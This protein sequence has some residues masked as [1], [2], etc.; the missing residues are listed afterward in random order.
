MV[1]HHAFLSSPSPQS[2][3]IA[4]RSHSQQWEARHPEAHLFQHQR[5]LRLPDN[6][7]IL[8]GPQDEEDEEDEHVG[9]G[10]RAGAG[11]QRKRKAP[12]NGEEKDQYQQGRVVTDAGPTGQSDAAA[13]AAAVGAASSSSAA[14]SES[15]QQ[16]QQQEQEQ[17][18]QEP[19]EQEPEDPAT[20]IRGLEGG[21]VGGFPG[22][23]PPPPRRGAAPWEQALL[24][25]EVRGAAAGAAGAAASLLCEGLGRRPSNGAAWE[26][27]KT[28]P[29]GQDVGEEHRSHTISLPKRLIAER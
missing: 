14:A 27:S 10:A 19:K 17:Q 11:G 23:P 8:P 22:W 4:T 21:A 25:M 5:F 6:F 18:D 15:Q 7:N 26:H 13:A 1:T 28:S 16:Q 24:E 12:G 3:G 29:A 2:N 20:T 9:A